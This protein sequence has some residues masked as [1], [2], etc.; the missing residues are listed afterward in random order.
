MIMSKKRT[1]VCILATILLIIFDQ[2]TKYLAVTNL[3]N[4]DPFVLIDGVFEFLY[5]ENRGVAWGAFSGRLG[6]FIAITLVILPVVILGIHR[7]NQMIAFFGNKV[8]IKILRFLQF[9]LF[10]LIAGAIGNLI[11]RALNGFVVDFLYFKLIDFPVFNVADCYITV[12]A[13]LFVII[14]LFFLKNNEFDYLTSSKKKWKVE[15]ED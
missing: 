14:G 9:D 12:A 3:K 7:I 10:M 13:V 15:N 4:N 5:V 6:W 1:I 11:D 8:N 2:F